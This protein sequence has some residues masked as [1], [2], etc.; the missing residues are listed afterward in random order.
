MGSNGYQCPTCKLVFKKPRKCFGRKG[1]KHPGVNCDE[2]PES[3]IVK[4]GMFRY[5]TNL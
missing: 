3:G 2:I 1:R 5:K 4:I